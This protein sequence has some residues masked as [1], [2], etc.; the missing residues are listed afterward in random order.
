[1][2]AAREKQVM[3]KWNPTRLSADISAETLQARREWHNIFKVLKGK[4]QQSRILY[5]ASLSFRFE[6]EKK[7]FIDKQKLKRVQ[8]H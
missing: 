5:L 4:T 2:K 8:H 6:G 1:M 7:H 3:Y